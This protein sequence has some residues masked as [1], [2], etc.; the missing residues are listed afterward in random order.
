MCRIR[1]CI[2][3]PLDLGLQY[4]KG[5]KINDIIFDRLEEMIKDLLFKLN[6]N[7]SLHGNDD[8]AFKISFVR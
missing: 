6:R 3:S 1:F 4:L 5:S 7:I 8:Y 2:V